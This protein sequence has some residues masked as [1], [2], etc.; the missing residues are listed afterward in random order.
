MKNI[1]RDRSFLQSALVS[2]VLLLIVTVAL[3][4]KLALYGYILFFGMPIVIGVPIGL[5]PNVR[6]AIFGSLL[7]MVL[8]VIAVVVL[9]LEAALCVM[10][11]LPLA[12]LVA[13]T[14]SALV[15]WYRRNRDYKNPPRVHLLLAPLLVFVVAIPIEQA[16]L[17]ND[18]VESEVR[19]VMELPYTTLEVYHAIKSVDTLDTDKSFLMHLGLP[20]PQKCILER[21]EPGAARVCYFEGGTIEER[22]T[23]LEPGKILAMDVTGYDLMGLHWL[24]F[25][26][27]I[28]TFEPTDF[29]GCR[30]TRITTYTSSLQPRFY[31]APLEKLGIGQEHDYVFRNLAKDLRNQ[32]FK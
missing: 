25:R 23:Q 5:L 27:A 11:Y 29:G 31:W 32:S 20:V 22:V 16:A 30:L 12:F 7:M 3:S 15:K 28:Y 2:S 1:I 24:G 8:F 18:N 21:E 10:L 17:G 19:T 13:A 14:T 4:S 6:N 9:K 26:K